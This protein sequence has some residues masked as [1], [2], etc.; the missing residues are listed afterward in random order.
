MQASGQRP[1]TLP[2]T[3]SSS[4][5]ALELRA[6][7]QVEGG[8]NVFSGDYTV[9]EDHESAVLKASSH[10]GRCTPARKR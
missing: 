7:K 3:T 10:S 6:I 5:T 8:R 9:D 2:S 4:E 1:V